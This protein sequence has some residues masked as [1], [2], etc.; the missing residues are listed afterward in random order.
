MTGSNQARGEECQMCNDQTGPRHQL[1]L[2]GR[3]G[4]EKTVTLR[5]CTECRDD[6]EKE[7]WIDIE[8]EEV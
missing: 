2:T 8:A 4:D 3:N 7:D 1:V 5:L 6:I